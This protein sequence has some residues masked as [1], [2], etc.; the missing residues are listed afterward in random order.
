MYGG[1]LLDMTF[2]GSAEI[3]IKGNVNVSKFAGRSGGPGGFIDISQNA[4]KVF[5][6]GMF[7]AGKQKPDI[8][9]TD[10]ELKINSDGNEIKYVKE[11]QQVTFSG[12]YAAKK[13]QEVVYISERAVFKLTP[14]G[15]MLIEIAPGVDLQKDVLDKMDFEPIIS[16]DLKIMDARLFS[17]ELMGLGG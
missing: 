5:F 10:G 15:V 2:L 3:D 7:T 12:E 14:E 4:K 17:E 6:V 13:G 16:P 9:V 11:V 8:K 1:G